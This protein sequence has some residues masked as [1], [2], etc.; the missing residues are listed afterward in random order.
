MTSRPPLELPASTV[1]DPREAPPLRWAVVSPGHIATQF[2]ETLERA[3]ASRAVAVTSRSAERA[4]AFAGAHGLD[5]A[6]VS[7]PHMLAAGGFDAVYIASPHSAHHEMARTVL[8]AGFPVLLEKAFTMTADE[9]RDLVSLARERGLFLME[10]LWSRFLPRFDVVRSVLAAGMLGEIVSLRA[11]HGQHFPFDPSHR[12]HAPELGG[13][14]LLDLGVYPVSF[15]QMVLG[16]LAGLTASGTLTPAG[17]DETVHVLASSAAHPRARASLVTTLAARAGNDA[18]ILG[19]EGRL[20]LEGMF[21]APGEVRVEMHDGR[22]ASLP[23]PTSIPGSSVGAEDG[24]AYEAAEAAR[25]ITAGDLES[26]LMTWH[27]TI[28]VM[29]ALDAARAQ[30]S[31]PDAPAPRTATDARPEETAR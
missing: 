9:A 19:T 2:T 12:L 13:G 30:V 1:A 31:A 28:A 29:E 22:T 18:E 23:D 27:D 6:F 14:A 21:F 26:P 5:A 15:A 3:T 25:R 10:A 24:L 20:V 7:L 4:D 16:D 11:T 8:E 17:V